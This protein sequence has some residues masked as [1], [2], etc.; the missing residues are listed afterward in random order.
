MEYLFEVVQPFMISGRGSVLASGP[1]TRDIPFKRR[2]KLVLPDKTEIETEVWGE[3][4]Y[5]NFAIMI[6]GSIENE[7]V[8][9][10]TEVW[11]YD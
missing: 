2:F 6:D 9:L 4:A 10:G 7:Q 1:R 8:P 11:L 3:G 5:E